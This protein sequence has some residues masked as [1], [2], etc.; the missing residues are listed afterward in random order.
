MDHKNVFQIHGLLRSSFNSALGS[1][2]LVRLAFLPENRAPLTYILWTLTII[3]LTAI[4]IAYTPVSKPERFFLVGIGI[5]PF[6]F[7]V[8][9]MAIQRGVSQAFPSNSVVS[10]LIQQPWRLRRPIIRYAFLREYLH[11]REIHY[12]V[13]DLKNCLDL[14][15]I[16]RD[17]RPPSSVN[18]LRHPIVVTLVGIYVY[19]LSNRFIAATDSWNNQSFVMTVSLVAILL[20][21]GAWVLYFLRSFD[22]NE[23]WQFECCLRWYM[24]HGKEEIRNKR[25]S[26]Q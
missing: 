11:A 2:S 17:N 26:T 3:M 12:T 25:P 6:F 18:F 20:L 1:R 4:G 16:N 8:S 23:E 14:I 15:E 13:D 21:W 24:L 5:M 7:F 19:I 9:E 10:N 22:P